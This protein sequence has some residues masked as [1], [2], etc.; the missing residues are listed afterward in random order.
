ME[1][2]SL[3]STSQNRTDADTRRR[4]SAWPAAVLFL[5]YMV[6]LADRYII[7][8]MVEPIKRDL[9]LSDTQVSLLHGLSFA[10]FLALAG[11]PIGRLVDTRRRTRLLTI[12]ITA[13]SALT[14][15]CGLAQT[16]VHLMVCRAG[17]A[18]GEASLQPAAYS[19]I[20]DYY[21]GRSMG[22]VVG[23]YS[24]GAY[25]GAGLVMI[26]SGAIVASLPATGIALPVVGVLQG[27][28]LVFLGAGAAGLV[29]AGLCSLLQEPAPASGVSAK[30]PL[31]D[32]VSLLRTN[33]TSLLG[34]NL[35]VAATSA[36]ANALI[37][38]TPTFFIR[39][40]GLDTAEVGASLGLIV[41]AFGALGA[42]SAGFLGGLLIR[43][44]LVNGRLAVLL[45][46]ALAA[47]PAAW[48][49]HSASSANSC[50]LFMAPLIFCVGLALG[51]GPA[52]LQ[53][54]SPSPTRGVVHA[55]AVLTSNLIGMGLGPT[56]VALLADYGPGR[57]VDIGGS[58]SILL[59]AFFAASALTAALTLRPY[60]RS[61]R[62]MP[63]RTVTK[64]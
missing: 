57:D 25:V 23:I 37:A 9:A 26:L 41:I 11:L 1:I 22:V 60:A 48:A 12:A 55:I 30:L 44:G 54:I 14:A 27:W 43:R 28:Q 52:I 51:S 32:V 13:W 18:V 62:R 3:A 17:V 56:A 29:A 4:V 38:W 42:I 39:R 64:P 46:A 19:L 35:A 40:F 50:L 58:L 7:S 34:V 49:A 45:A 10:I 47:A 8:L 63:P 20:G 53:D 31:R 5:A 61:I 15:A 33:F 59:P 2:A 36:G 21:P 6:A 24:A 16:F